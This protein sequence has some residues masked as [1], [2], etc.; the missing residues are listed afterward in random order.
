[1][2][3]KV[4]GTDYNTQWVTPSGGGGGT[5]INF[6]QVQ[7]NSGS[8]Q[9]LTGTA[10]YVDINSTIWNTAFIGTGFSWDGSELTVSSASDAIEF[11]VSIQGITTLNNRV[12]IGG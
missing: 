3:E 8:G 12:E 5:T 4:D 1:M 7:D 2:L 11:N 6:F 10:S 9:T